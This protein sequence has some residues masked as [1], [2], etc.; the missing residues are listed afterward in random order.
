VTAIL[1]YLPRA[2]Y[3]SMPWRNGAGITHEIA[4][5]PPAAENFEWRLSLAT[6]AQSGPF[7]AYPG[8]HRSVTLIEGAGFR[9]D[10]E[11]QSAAELRV[12]GQS[13]AFPGGVATSC[14]LFDGPSTDLSLMVRDPGTIVSVTVQSC[15]IERAFSSPAA[16]QA[17]FCLAGSVLLSAQDNKI[18]LAPFE[19]ALLG[20]DG[21][22]C[23]VL[24]SQS[25][26]CV[27]VRLEWSL[28]RV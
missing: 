16:M 20:S 9:L 15:D 25:S 1:N 8:Y 18:L 6:V 5:E 7:S 10:V 2:Q 21:P 13:V 12:S 23:T 26:A 11:G 4:R 17:F 28:S 3:Q 22:S 14:S 27:L 24:A 19:T